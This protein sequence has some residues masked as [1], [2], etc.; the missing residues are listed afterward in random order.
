MVID[1]RQVH[2]SPLDAGMIRIKYRL[3]TWYLYFTR[4]TEGLEWMRYENK[5]FCYVRIAEQ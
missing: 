2:V 3:E 4:P 1:L 5:Q